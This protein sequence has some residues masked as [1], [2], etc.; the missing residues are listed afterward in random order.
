[1]SASAATA[2]VS[3]R[4]M[5]GPRLMRT[6]RGRDRIAARSSSSKPPS[7]PI[8]RLTPPS[9]REPA[10]ASS[11]LACLRLL[12]AEHQQ[13]PGRPALERLG[14]RLDRRDFRRPDHAALLASLDRIQAQTLEVHAGDLGVARDDGPQAPRAHLD[15]LLRHIVEPCV[16]ERRE[17]I[18]DVRRRLLGPRARA[19]DERG[20]LAR[21][22]R[23]AGGEF[24]VAA[25]EQKD[26]RPRA[27][28]EHVDEVV[29]L[30]SV[31][32]DFP[33]RGERLVDVEAGGSEI[34]SSHSPPIAC[35]DV[36]RHCVGRAGNK[37]SLRGE[38][39]FIGALALAF[40]MEE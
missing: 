34:G 9:A 16:L 18:V 10:S 30:L 19:D 3:A 32:P 21:I 40:R 20:R 35:V 6:T 22:R 11:G 29:R 33:A 5:R 24:A 36:G 7:G 25:I 31:E 37:S 27:E 8:R 14:K 2:A 26:L 17:Q 38:C 28:P 15:R 12:V 13:P 39:A 1:M 23:E 4:R